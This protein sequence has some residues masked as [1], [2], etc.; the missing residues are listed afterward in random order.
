MWHPRQGRSMVGRD[1]SDDDRN[2]A[3]KRCTVAEV[4]HSPI[5]GPVIGSLL[6]R[7]VEAAEEGHCLLGERP[8]RWLPLPALL[9]ECCNLSRA[10]LRG[11]AGERQL[12]T[13][14]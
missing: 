6:I 1:P 11:P 14:S 9:H 10:L 7:A 13:C 3:T 2:P 5:Q 12:Q 8:I 4:H